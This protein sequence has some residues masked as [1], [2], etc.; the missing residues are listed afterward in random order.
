MFAKGRT[1]EIT[2]GSEARAGRRY[3]ILEAFLWVAAIVG[4]GGV[5]WLYHLYPY[6]P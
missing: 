1:G 2:A 4:W 5:A 6:L 3:C